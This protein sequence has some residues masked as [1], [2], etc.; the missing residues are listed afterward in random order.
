MDRAHPWRGDGVLPLHRQAAYALA[1]VAAALR[2]G[3]RPRRPPLGLDEAALARLTLPRGALARLA[4]E[5]SA[6]ALPPW[7]LAHSL[8]TWAWGALLALRDGLRHD[9]D[10][11]YAAALL[12]D[13]G[14]ADGHRPPPGTCFAVWGARRAQEALLARGA[15]AP[16]ADLVARAIALHLEV[17]VG[18]AQ[19]PEASLL[20]RGAGL[21]V[22]GR[23]ARALAR[24]L[25]DEVV[26]RWPRQGMKGHLRTRL[27]EEG[28]RAPGTRLWL[29]LHLGFARRIEAAPFAE[30][31][32]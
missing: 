22:V 19:G 30:G 16:A 17:R 5:I 3:R 4:E 25:R 32:P 7:L 21:D 13:L 10:L 14:L 28:R 9:P 1:A 2:A 18:A 15:G 24:P 11:L 26:R 23:E 31:R 8:R 29:L 20:A 6:P 27:A 12:H